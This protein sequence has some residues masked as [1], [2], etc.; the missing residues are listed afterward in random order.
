MASHAG[1]ASFYIPPTCLSQAAKLALSCAERHWT[2]ASP[3]PVAESVRE[4]Q[5]T[6]SEAQGARRKAM[7][8]AMKLNLALAAAYPPA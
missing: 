4:A 2:H 1:A 7:E 8:M 3:G 5:R 6:A